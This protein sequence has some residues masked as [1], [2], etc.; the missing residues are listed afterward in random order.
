ML[1]ALLAVAGTL[2]GT[3]VAAQLQ[4]RSARRAE[5][6]QRRER[7]R[8]ETIDAVRHLAGALSDHRRAMY[9]RA[10]AA[11]AG[12]PHELIERLR[13]DSHHTRSQVNQP[14]LAL[15]LLV[16]DRTVRTAADTMIVATY[17]M[18]SAGDSWEA[19]E[20]AR[21][22]AVEAHDAFVD[23]AARHLQAADR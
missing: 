9:L 16:T 8:A 20:A 5:A 15:R 3:A 21:V 11:L 10:E 22:Q 23:S 7:A 2:L 14:H 13:A 1:T 18:R 19:L 12:S 6:V 17:A 4:D